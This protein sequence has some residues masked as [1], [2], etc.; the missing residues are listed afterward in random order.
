MSTTTPSLRPLT[1]EARKSMQR[2]ERLIEHV[3]QVVTED[4]ALG[5][6]CELDPLPRRQLGYDLALQLLATLVEL[7]DLPAQV[8]LCGIG[9]ALQLFD[10]AL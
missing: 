7:V 8:H 3:G 2:D 1:E 4:G 10:L 6:P 9:E 5:M